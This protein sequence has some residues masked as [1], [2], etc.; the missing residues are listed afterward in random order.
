M[1]SNENLIFILEDKKTKATIYQFE[2]KILGFQKEML[3]KE[4]VSFYYTFKDVV[5]E[6]ENTMNTGF[7]QSSK[8]ETAFKIILEDKV[9]YGRDL[10]IESISEETVS[11]WEM[12]LYL[13]FENAAKTVL[14]KVTEEHKNYI[15]SSKEK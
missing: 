8:N 15:L 14:N 7:A 1:S 6:A 5:N 3:T 2:A 10:D 4:D 12:S 9:L 13:I 11:R